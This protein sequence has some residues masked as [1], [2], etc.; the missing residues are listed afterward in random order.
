[1]AGIECGA[2]LNSDS[3]HVLVPP[4]AIARMLRMPM[5]ARRHPDARLIPADTKDPRAPSPRIWRAC[6]LAGSGRQRTPGTGRRN[7][8]S[9]S[10][11]LRPVKRRAFLD[12]RPIGSAASVCCRSS[13]RT[14]TATTTMTP[15]ASPKAKT[16]AAAITRRAM[17]ASMLGPAEFHPQVTLSSGPGPARYPPPGGRELLCSSVPSMCRAVPYVRLR[18]AVLLT[19]A[20]WQILVHPSSQT[21]RI[22]P[23][24]PAFGIIPTFGTCY[25]CTAVGLKLNRRTG[26]H[27]GELSGKDGPNRWDRSYDRVHRC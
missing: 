1:M 3:I 6:R 8:E 11:Q 10:R 4:P 5:P 22:E 17:T 27:P 14:A 20:S 7:S 18:L 21:A 15:D 26:K 13:R 25:G 23:T 24:C 12:I 9:R 19:G 2:R 16:A